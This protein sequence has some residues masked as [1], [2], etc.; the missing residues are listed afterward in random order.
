MGK[1]LKGHNL[2]KGIS[3]RKDGYYVARFTSV[4]GQ[5]TSKIFKK[6]PEARLWLRDS[7]YEDAHSK[8]KPVKHGDMTVTAWF[9]YRMKN[10]MSSHLKYNTQVSYNGR[11]ENR[12]KPMMGDMSLSEVKPMDC[13]RVMDYCMG[14]EDASGSIAKIR[15]IMSELLTRRHQDHN[16]SLRSFN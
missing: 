2:D 16:E 14:K 6:L 5:R 1:D 9:E 15:S 4:N 11:F 3:Q 8:P 10:L 12:I 13:Q 7:G